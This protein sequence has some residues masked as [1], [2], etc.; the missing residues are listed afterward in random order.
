MNGG[1]LPRNRKRKGCS[2]YKI[3]ILLLLLVGVN[4]T[5]SKVH[6]FRLLSVTPAEWMGQPASCMF[7]P[8]GTLGF[9]IHSGSSSDT[10]VPS[11]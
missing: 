9:I 8:A 4:H 6:V 2:D 3:R 5:Q 11:I 1:Q 10:S 7:H